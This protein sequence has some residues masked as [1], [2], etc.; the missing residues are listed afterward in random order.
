MFEKLQ[1]LPLLIGLSDSEMME[2]LENVKFEFNKYDEG[3]TI[4][5]QGDRCEKTI[6]ILKGEICVDRRG[7]DMI[8]TEYVDKTPFLLEPENMWGMKQK[9]THTYSFNTDGNTCSI[10]KKQLS[11]MISRYGVMRTNLLSMV[12]NKLQT[13]NQALQLPVSN[14]LEVRVIRYFSNNMLTKSGRKSI[15]VK[16]NTLADAV[17]ATRLNISK[18]LNSWQEKNLVSLGRGMI[19]IPEFADILAISVKR[20]A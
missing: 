2:I 3:A 8:F 20:E 13:T 4:V 1:E 6:Y 16:M 12:C 17:D 11:Y 15:R 19:E 5:N 10:D 18:V 9:Y 14:D 7:G